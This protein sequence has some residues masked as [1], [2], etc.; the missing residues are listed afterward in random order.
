MLTLQ[1]GNQYPPFNMDA[2][3]TVAIRETL[4]V[5][6]ARWISVD[7]GKYSSNLGS[8]LHDHATDG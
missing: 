6:T 8:P 4:Q 2:I 3:S 5:A 1:P 7:P